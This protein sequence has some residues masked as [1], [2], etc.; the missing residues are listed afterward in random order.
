MKTALSMY[1]TVGMVLDQA[2]QRGL[3]VDVDLASGRTLRAVTVAALEQHSVV[4][5]AAANQDRPGRAHIV[6]RD[7][8]VGVSMDSSDLLELDR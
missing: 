3:T 7:H 2:H 5:L 4:L 1:V 8:V 6:T